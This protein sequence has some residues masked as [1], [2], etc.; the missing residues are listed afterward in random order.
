MEQRKGGRERKG[1]AEGRDGEEDG[2]PWRRGRGRK[3]AGEREGD[4]R[5]AVAMGSSEIQEKKRKR[6]KR[7]GRR[8]SSADQRRE[9]EWGSITW[10]GRRP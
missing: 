6:E 2:R 7:A 1:E 8:E 4:G 3:G 9:S 5:G 10:V